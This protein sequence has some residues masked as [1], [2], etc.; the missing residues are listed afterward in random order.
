M[1]SGGLE[2]RC[3][4]CHEWARWREYDLLFSFRYN[5]E[6]IYTVWKHRLVRSSTA[7]L[8]SEFVMTMFRLICEISIF[9]VGRSRSNE[10]GMSFIHYLNDLP[11]QDIISNI[12]S[13][14]VRRP[15]ADVSNCI[16]YSSTIPANYRM[17]RIKQPRGFMI[18][19]LYRTMESRRDSVT[20]SKRR[21]NPIAQII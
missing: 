1:L 5:P 21:P 13:L 4:S 10:T 14:F 18:S 8:S 7:A 12:Q 17:I 3:A 20:S 6:E 19:S 11:F 15:D 2:N 16:R 9:V